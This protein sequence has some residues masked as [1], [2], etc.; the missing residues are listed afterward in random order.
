MGTQNRLMQGSKPF[1]RRI[2]RLY[3]EVK[4]GAADTAV[5]DFRNPIF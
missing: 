5:D 1:M 2:V 3:D 4:N